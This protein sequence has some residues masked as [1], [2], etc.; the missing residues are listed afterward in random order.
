MDW[1]VRSLG[2]LVLA[3]SLLA[4]AAATAAGEELRTPTGLVAMAS[5]EGPITVG[6]PLRFRLGV[7]N[8]AP[9]A[10]AFG[11][12]N[13]LF[14]L[15]TL[16]PEPGKVYLSDAVALTPA[17]PWPATLAAG[18]TLSFQSVDVGST[19]VHLMSGLR[20]ARSGDRLNAML[21]P[22]SARVRW[23]VS[24]PQPNSAPPLHFLSEWQEIAV[25]LSE[26]VAAPTNALLASADLLL[27]FNRD[28]WSA[29]KA[30]DEAV[31]RG[32]ALLPDLV[33]AAQERT[34]P[35][36]A[37]MWL[38]TTIADIPGEK[39]VAGLIALLDDPAGEVRCVV[40]YHG[41]KQRSATLDQA[42]LATAQKSNSAHFTAYALLGFLAFRG[43][44]PD[45]LVKTGVENEDPRARS[46]A[47][48]ILANMANDLNKSRL[49]ALLQDK[50]ERVRATARKVL[51]AMQPKD[52][53]V[54]PAV[55]GR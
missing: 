37:R 22:G 25:P 14:A 17:T 26:P 20:Q 36:F 52:K 1:S 16:K 7:S 41:P 27:R 5:M 38:A 55:P 24:V 31:K 35:D 9:T 19:T 54:E 51:D 2:L 34:R 10:L 43:E 45:A 33:A 11:T 39:A 44:A 21:T 53:V 18:A 50:D 28:A 48:G 15:L 46:T 12:T 32:A 3:A 23:C 13:K 29:Q 40:A 8:S 49:Q 6:G 4:S 47:A 42:I 30:H